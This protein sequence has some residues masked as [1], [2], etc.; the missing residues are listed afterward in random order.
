[1]SRATPQAVQFAKRLMDYETNGKKSPKTPTQAAFPV[2]EKLR[3][4]LAT[5]M[6]NGGFQALL[7]RALVLASEQV[8]WLSAASVQPGGDVAGLEEAQAQLGPDEW[9]EGEVVLF[10]QLIGLLV[11]FIGE[12]LTLRLVREIWPK[13]PLRDLD[14]GKGNYNEKAK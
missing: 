7:S 5:L 13:I 14:F 6:G 3:P 10:A 11:A 9:A 1:M 4:T 8:P 12:N 2:C